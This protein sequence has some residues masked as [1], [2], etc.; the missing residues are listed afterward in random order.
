MKKFFLIPLLI[1]CTLF[2]SG[3]G[4]LPGVVASSIHVT[5]SGYDADAQAYIDAVN[6]V[7]TLTTTQKDKIDRYVRDLKGESNGSYSTTNQWSKYK[8]IYILIW[9]DAGAI[10]YNLKDPR[11][12]DAAF[13]LTFTGGTVGASY[14]T[15]GGSGSANTHLTPSSTLSLTSAAIGAWADNYTAEWTL[16]FDASDGNGTLHMYGTSA[17]DQTYVRIWSDLNG[18][19]SLNKGNNDAPYGLGPL[20]SFRVGSRTTASAFELY[21][22]GSEG[23]MNTT[24]TTTMSTTAMPAVP[25]TLGNNGHKYFKIMFISDGLTHTEMQYHFSAANALL[26]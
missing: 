8:A 7:V 16:D 10:K 15:P 5:G 1:L 18:G 9:G 26:N 13:R 12:L 2:T 6:P 25:V 21:I 17:T 11:N 23:E 3:Q 22:N 24:T 14:W 19:E 20:P 4:V